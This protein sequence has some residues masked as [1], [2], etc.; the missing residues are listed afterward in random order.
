MDESL[1]FDSYTIE[2]AIGFLKQHSGTAYSADL[3]VVARAAFSHQRNLPSLGYKTSP[4]PLSDYCKKW[5]E[6]YLK[7]YNNRP[8]VR[9]KKPSATHPDSIMKTI[10]LARLDGKTAEFVDQLEAGHQVIMNLEN[11]VGELLEEYLSVKLKENGWY[12]CWGSTIDA[13]DFCK[14]DG[15]LLQIK[16]SDNSENS[17]SSRV[18][19]GTEIKK[20]YRRKST[21][22]DT[23]MWQDLQALVGRTDLTEDN[24]RAYVAN[25][26]STN[27]DCVYLAEDNI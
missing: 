26:V 20:W 23:F 17:S 15:T 25:V 24:F 5:A 2:A 6:R 11:L 8:S 27:P 9:K 21:K 18:R 12:C 16:N 14:A 13:V 4:I 7:G 3:E 19:I 22:K 1:K 10:L